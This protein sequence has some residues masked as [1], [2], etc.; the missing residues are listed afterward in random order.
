MMFESFSAGYWILPNVE[1]VEYGGSN[2]IVQ[3]ALFD[4]LCWKIGSESIIASTGGNHY[5][6][7]PES[8]IPA[9]T[10]AIP[11]EW[12]YGTNSG[13]P[14]L[15]SKNDGAKVWERG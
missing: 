7:Y 14:L 4:R 6:L 15:I 3:D 1:V 9:N 8:A 10:V 11:R 13:S 12:G 2:A 5:R